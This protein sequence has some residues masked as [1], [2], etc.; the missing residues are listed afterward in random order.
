[1]AS[2]IWNLF[3]ELQYSAQLLRAG[4]LS[5]AEPDVLEE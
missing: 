4:Q 5:G 2:L 1:M 3:A